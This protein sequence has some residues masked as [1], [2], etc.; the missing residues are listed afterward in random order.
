MAKVRIKKLPEGYKIKGGKITKTSSPTVSRTGDQSDFGLVTFTGNSNV[1]NY[2]PFST[3]NKTLS[4]EP[5]D[6]SNLEAERGETALTDLNNDGAFELY[7]IGGNRHSSGGTPLNLPP[8][9]FIYS[10]TRSMKL[11]KNELLEMG[12]KSKKKITPAKVSKKYDLNDYIALLNDPNSDHITVDTAEYMLDKNKNKLSQLAFIQER[13]KEFDEGVPMAAYPYIKKK[14]ADPIE[15][16]QAVENISKEEAVA[17]AMMQMPASMQEKVMQLQQIFD[18]I[19]AIKDPNQADIDKA[20]R[21]EIAPHQE[22]SPPQ[23]NP[24][25]VP[26]MEQQNLEMM[27]RYGRELPKAGWGSSFMDKFQ[28]GLSAVGMIPGI[29]NI[30][31]AANVA[32]SGGRAAYAGLT[33]DTEAAKKHGKAM[34]LNAVAMVPGVGQMSQAAR[35]AKGA[36]NI[37]KAVGDDAVKYT[38]KAL[39]DSTFKYGH[40]VQDVKN[41]AKNVTD[42]NLL[43]NTAVVGT[44]QG[45]NL[46]KKADF[47]TGSNVKNEIVGKDKKEEQPGQM[48]TTPGSDQLAQTTTTPPTTTTPT[49]PPP[50]TAAIPGMPGG[51]PGMPAVG[52]QAAP[53]ATATAAPSPTTTPSTTPAPGA[54]IAQ[55]TTPP[56]TTTTPGATAAAQSATAA[57]TDTTPGATTAAAA[58]TEPS[59]TDVTAGADETTPEEPAV[60]DEPVEEEV[61]AAAEPEEEEYVPQTQ[62]D[63]ESKY[64]GDPFSELKAFV[65]G[66]ELEMYQLAGETDEDELSDEDQ[67]KQEEGVNIAPRKQGEFQYDED[68]KWIRDMMRDLG[69][70]I[71]DMDDLG[72]IQGIDQQSGI[73]DSEYFADEEATSKWMMSPEGQKWHYENNKQ[74]FA[75][76]GIMSYEDYQDQY[77]GRGSDSTIVQDFQSQHAKGA[78]NAWDSDAELREKMIAAYGDEETAK[79][80]YM[81][82]V[83]FGD[84]GKGNPFG[85]DNKHGVYTQGVSDFKKSPMEVVCIKCSEDGKQISQV[86]SKKDGCGPGWFTEG[87][88]LDCAPA[89]EEVRELDEPEEIQPTEEADPE[90]WLQDQLGLMNAID[91]KFRIKKYYPWAPRVDKEQI[92]AV[93]QDPTREIAAIGEQAAIAAQTAT[94]FSGPQR[95]AAVQAK[96]QGVAAQQIADTIARTQGANV[97]TANIVNS[98]NVELSQTADIVNKESLKKLYDDTILTEQNYDNALKEANAEITKQMQNMYTNRAYTHNLNQLYPEF[99]INPATGGIAQFDP[100]YQGDLTRATTA[101]DGTSSQGTNVDNYLAMYNIDKDKLTAEER[102]ALYKSQGFDA[103]NQHQGAY[104]FDNRQAML[105]MMNYPGGVKSQRGG[106]NKR[107]RIANKGAELRKWFSP[108]RGKWVD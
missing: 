8:Q 42:P 22:Q 76:M 36:A 75:N 89:V 4:P 57:A 17:K 23:L 25:P 43:T 6:R 52:P 53:T 86:F 10:D 72:S 3:V 19:D 102:L 51:I 105:N 98:K 11:N 26:P 38:G 27:A 45:V 49:A 83:T 16:S 84:H 12:I 34:A 18:Q 64:G 59:A 31:D 97:Q 93:F 40:K 14:G 44:T 103:P 20:N 15:F 61:T 46:A 95:A 54:S 107:Q 90:F 78:L 104:H 69:Y 50:V 88:A 71:Q 82:S 29:G 79:Q 106:E 39:K 5:R 48:P 56:A 80:A 81:Q 77:V 62:R 99:N 63:E 68:A 2:G 85:K 100:S 58:A 21:Q 96:A 74:S 55:A 92:D 35:G 28:T 41:I 101:M 73:P 94:A 65:D 32:I 91:N 33:G 108:L 47:V 37:V 24:I 1:D 30:A 87:T 70:N 13:K 66:E 7:N 60:V 9:S 67:E